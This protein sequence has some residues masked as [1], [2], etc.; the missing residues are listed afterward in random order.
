MDHHNKSGEVTFNEYY[1]WMKKFY[2]KKGYPLSK[3]QAYKK[4][5]YNKFLGL[6]G[7]KRTFNKN[8]VRH[9]VLTTYK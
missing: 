6:S 8:D 9:Y 1:R 7:G 2:L 4:G 3:I 5:F